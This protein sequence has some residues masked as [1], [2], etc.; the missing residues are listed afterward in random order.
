MELTVTFRF[1]KQVSFHLLLFRVSLVCVC[2]VSF[3]IAILQGMI[4]II[5]TIGL[6]VGNL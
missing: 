1:L 5:D 2:N 3:L 6:T 4:I